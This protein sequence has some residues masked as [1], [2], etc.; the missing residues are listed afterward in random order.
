MVSGEIALHAGPSTIGREGVKTIPRS[1]A[2]Q[3]RLSDS[4]VIW[5]ERGNATGV[6]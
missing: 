6:L 4:G 2:I 3:Y 1:A 5:F